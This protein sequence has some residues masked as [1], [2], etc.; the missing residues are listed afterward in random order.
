MDG[1]AL[2]RLF[3]FLDAV[4][5]VVAGHACYTAEA[6]DYLGVRF[7]FPTM[8]EADYQERSS[9]GAANDEQ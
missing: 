7:R 5:A 3:G 2:Q 6:Y 8:E 1:E 4:R 9:G